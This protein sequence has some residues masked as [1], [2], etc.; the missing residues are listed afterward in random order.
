[1]THAKTKLRIATTKTKRKL[2]PQAKPFR[3]RQIPVAV[4]ALTSGIFERSAVARRVSL[5]A[6]W[7]YGVVCEARGALGGKGM[8]PGAGL[9]I[10]L[11]KR[12]KEGAEGKG[13]RMA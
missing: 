7:L 10:S 11:R 1:M 13:S 3:A 9:G 4:W 2:K 8:M 12:E 5:Q 6:Q